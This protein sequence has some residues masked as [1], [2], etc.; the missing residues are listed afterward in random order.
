[1]AKKK[2][3]KPRGSEPDSYESAWAELQKILL[4]MQ[5][6]SVGVD[7]LTERIERMSALIHFCRAK[8]RNTEEAISRLSSE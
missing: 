3:D 1:M 7:E 8:L 5:S 4:E 2:T 6:G